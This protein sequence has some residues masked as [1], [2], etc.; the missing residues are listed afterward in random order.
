MIY[1]SLK[2]QCGVLKSIKANFIF[3]VKYYTKRSFIFNVFVIVT[4]LP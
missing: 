1:G 4:N 2:C 3:S